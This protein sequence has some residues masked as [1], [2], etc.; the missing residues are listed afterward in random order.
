MEVEHKYVYKHCMK[1]ICT[2][3]NKYDDGTEKI[4]VSGKYK[5]TC[6]SLLV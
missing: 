5:V 2:N 6:I 4:D 1:Y 3:N